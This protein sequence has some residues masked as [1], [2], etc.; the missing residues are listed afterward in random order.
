[1]FDNIHPEAKKKII[2]YE[3]KNNITEY[4]IVYLHG[5]F[6]TGHQQ[7]DVLIKIAKKLKANLFLSSLSGHGAGYEATKK[8][9]AK[10]FYEDAAEAVAIGNKIGK[11][12]S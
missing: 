11:K 8:L 3:D 6:A 1:M 12:Q 10:N 5:S 7:Q 4:S 2:W 9:E